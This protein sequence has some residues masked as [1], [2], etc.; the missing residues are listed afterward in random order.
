MWEEYQWDLLR[1]SVERAKMA[2]PEMW[3]CV[4]KWKLREMW[5][6]RREAGVPDEWK[7]ICEIPK[8]DRSWYSWHRVGMFSM[9][10]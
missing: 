9:N 8:N 4:G 6:D 2:I 3:R 1:Q 5:S 7:S 10:E